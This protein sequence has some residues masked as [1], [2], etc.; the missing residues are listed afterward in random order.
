MLLAVALQ[1][2][3]LVLDF[4][5]FLLQPADLEIIGARSG[6][7]FLDPRLQYS[8]LLRKLREMSGKRHIALRFGVEGKPSV[9]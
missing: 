4:E 6:H 5:L 1:L 8:V 7:L 3:H 2:D 9:T